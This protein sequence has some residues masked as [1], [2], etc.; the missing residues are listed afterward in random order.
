MYLA[1]EFPFLDPTKKETVFEWKSCMEI[2]CGVGN[3]IVPLVRA[4]PDR[5]FVA[6]DFAPNAVALLKVRLCRRN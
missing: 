4:F 5:K 6:S 3:T 1:R 2:G